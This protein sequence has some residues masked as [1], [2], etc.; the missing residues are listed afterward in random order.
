MEFN[1]IISLILGFIVLILIFVWV[2]SRFRSATRE[3]TRTTNISITPTPTKG[4]NKGWNPFGFL[5]FGGTKT[6]SPSVTSKV[7]PKATVTVS[8]EVAIVKKETTN[9]TQV[10][11]HNNNTG[12]TSEY[13]ITGVKQIP[14]TGIATIALPVMFSA[15]SLGVYLRRRF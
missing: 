6:P 5:F 2:G 3:S 9:Q 4:E 10:D 11:Y 1:R 15:F 13:N 12:Q 14:S 7:T 8:G